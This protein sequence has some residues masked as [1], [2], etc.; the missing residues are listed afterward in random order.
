MRRARA[1][2]IAEGSAK[3]IRE[4]ENHIEELDKT[5]LDLQRS[6][7]RDGGRNEEERA[8]RPMVESVGVD[9]SDLPQPPAPEQP[10]STPQMPSPPPSPVH[11]VHE[12][13]PRVD[14]VVAMRQLLKV[15][16]VW[17][18]VRGVLCV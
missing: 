15:R 11:A 18:V 12:E 13:S 4:L 3:R 8:S 10:P 6:A 9:T 16:D 5:V 14:P 2:T 7:P 1:E 17:C